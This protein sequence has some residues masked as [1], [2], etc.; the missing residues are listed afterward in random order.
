MTRFLAT[1]DKPDG[2][3]L[4]DILTEIQNDIVRRSLKIIGDRRPE[5]HTVLHNNIEILNWLTACIHKAE[6]STRVLAG[7]GPSRAHDGGP[8]RIGAA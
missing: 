3:R 6:D 1:D 2:W 7:L 4:E 5:A 8:P